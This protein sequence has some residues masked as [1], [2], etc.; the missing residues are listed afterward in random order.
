MSYSETQRD[1][2]ELLFS[3]YVDRCRA[4]EQIDVASF[5]NENPELKEE[6]LEL[7]PTLAAL[8]SFKKQGPPISDVDQQQI[9]SGLQMGE[10]QL[11]REIGVGGMGIVYEA[12]QKSIQRRVAL[13]VLPR[14]FS[15]QKDRRERFMQ[16]ARTVAQLSYRNIVPI[17]DFGEAD[18]RCFFAMRLVE[19]VGL[20]WVVLR[21]NQNSEPITSNEV[22]DHFQQQGV[23]LTGID[24]ETDEDDNDEDSLA[25]EFDYAAH[26]ATQRAK[27]QPRW[28]LKPDSWKQIARIGV[29][30]ARALE[31]AH[32]AG[33]LHRDIKPGNLLLDYEGILWIT[34]FGLAKSEKEL[35]ITGTN[36]VVGTMRYISPERFHGQVDARSDL[37]A[38]GLT[39]FE[40]CI[41]RPVFNQT[42]RSELMRSIIEGIIPAP[43][44]INSKIPRGLEAILVK[45]T[46]KQPTQR[47]QSAAEMI[48]DLRAFGRGLEVKPITQIKVRTKKNRN[49][50]PGITIAL[51]LLCL[52]EAYLL[53]NYR[54]LFP[55]TPQVTTSVQMKAGALDQRLENLDRMYNQVTGRAISTD[56]TRT[57]PLLPLP[58]N[59]RNLMQTLL[60]LYRQL[61][62]DNEQTGSV[63]TIEDIDNRIQFIRKLL[64]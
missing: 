64:S 9:E 3:E 39:L 28:T 63:F 26:S 58:D 46:A 27:Q 54:V 7:F 29:Q 14:E 36:D 15:R 52:L 38:L 5:A 33:I 17:I 45:A 55:R 41:N 32:N 35:S 16:E 62:K 53:A 21:R 47:Y 37:Y 59:Q 6:I 10:Y 23:P 48:Q 22:L 43:R 8:E 19:G 61:R 30:A 60:N 24:K 25:F 13:K 11:L 1:P 56:L 31:H 4:G 42:N 44:S 51:L 34:D 12:F 2:L 57:S 20:D 18:Q 50:L 40:L 49:W